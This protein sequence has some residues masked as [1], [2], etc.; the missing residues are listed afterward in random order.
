MVMRLVPPTRVPKEPP[1]MLVKKMIDSPEK[2]MMGHG[3]HGKPVV[4]NKHTPLRTW[5]LQRFGAQAQGFGGSSAA[6]RN[7]PKHSRY[8]V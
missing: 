1:M 6:W 3:A 4:S 8:V 7:P 5:A 2:S